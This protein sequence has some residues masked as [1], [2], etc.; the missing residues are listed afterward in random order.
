MNNNNNNVNNN[1]NNNNEYS[2]RFISFR[3]SPKPR[4]AASLETCCQWALLNVQYFTT[5]INCTEVHLSFCNHMHENFE[6]ADK[7]TFYLREAAAG[8][9]GR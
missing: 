9:A 4:R 7:W 5:Y 6:S 1:N 8:V 3:M 2:M